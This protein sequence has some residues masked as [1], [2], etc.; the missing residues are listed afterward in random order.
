MS[1]TWHAY[2]DFKDLTRRAH[3]DKI[4]HNKAFITAKNPKYDKYQRC[5]ASIFIIFSIFIN[6]WQKAFGE[7]F[8]NKFVSNKELAKELHKP[9]IK[10][11]KQKVYSVFVVPI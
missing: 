10:K 6:F 3:S 5:I 7:A 9:V 11:I 2:R 1:S 4:L 8:K